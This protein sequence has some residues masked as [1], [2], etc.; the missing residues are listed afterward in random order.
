MIFL[1]SHELSDRAQG[2]FDEPAVVGD[3]DMSLGVDCIER[4]HYA[5]VI[6]KS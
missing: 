6:R 4:G 1:C 2:T 3:H 5:T